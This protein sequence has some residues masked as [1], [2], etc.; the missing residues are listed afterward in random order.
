MKWLLNCYIVM[1]PFFIAIWL[2]IELKWNISFVILSIINIIIAHF[3]ITKN[4]NN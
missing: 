2:W 4:F 3:L 1:L